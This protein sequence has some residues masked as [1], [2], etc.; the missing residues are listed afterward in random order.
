MTPDPIFAVLSGYRTAA[1]LKAAIDLDCFSAIA[2]G[3]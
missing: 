3:R 1:A 2:S